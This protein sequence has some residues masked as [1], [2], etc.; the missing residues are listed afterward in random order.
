MRGVIL[1]LVFAGFLAAP[2]WAE[3]QEPPSVDKMVERLSTD[4]DLNAEQ[5][6]KVKA[7]M[8]E[9]MAKREDMMKSAVEPSQMEQMKA[10]EEDKLSQVLTPEQ[11]AKWKSI[12]LEHARSGGPGYEAG[13]VAGPGGPGSGDMPPQGAPENGE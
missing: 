8:D 13:P 7:I 9:G 11:L 12:M 2:V 5:A 6:A 4:L 1:S 10:E 3:P